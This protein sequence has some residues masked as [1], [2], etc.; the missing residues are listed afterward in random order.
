MT[1]ILTT[2]SEIVVNIAN[3]EEWSRYWQFWGTYTVPVPLF[4]TENNFGWLQNY[5]SPYSWGG[6]SLLIKF[7]DVNFKDPV[8]I[9]HI[10]AKH[11]TEQTKCHRVSKLF[12][13]FKRNTNDVFA[14][15]QNL[16]PGWSTLQLSL[17]HHCNQDKKI[18][19]FS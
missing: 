12:P 16:F 19:F 7:L 14:F 4:N 2:Q 3:L 11:L 13:V 17:Y 8:E 10:K 1:K 9:L 5:V 6:L 18:I 15:K